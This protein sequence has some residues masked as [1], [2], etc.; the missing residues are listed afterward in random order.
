MASRK[1]H[2]A[3][4]RRT[5]HGKPY[6]EVW[7]GLGDAIEESP[8]PAALDFPC[9][10]SRDDLA[11]ELR[12][13]YPGIEVRHG[14]R[15]LDSAA[16]MRSLNRKA[17]RGEFI[18]YWRGQLRFAETRGF[19]DLND[20]YRRFVRVKLSGKDRVRWCSGWFHYPLL[21]EDSRRQM[22]E[23]SERLQS[24]FEQDRPNRR[25]VIEE[26]YFEQVMRERLAIFERRKEN[27]RIIRWGSTT[28]L[29]LV[30]AAWSL[31]QIVD[32]LV[33]G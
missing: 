16:D 22:T 3:S 6:Y 17:D 7:L 31:M 2:R 23:S 21:I 14:E 19:D 8:M 9:K 26:A 15:G 28:A 32:K 4:I 13:R 12:V 24:L 10:P 30:L 33:G 11:A 18:D 29:G 20:P 25:D 1:I 5:A 27:W